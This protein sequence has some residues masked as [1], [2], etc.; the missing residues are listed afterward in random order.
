MKSAVGKFEDEWYVQKHGIATGGS[1]CVELANIAVYF[2][3][4]ERVY[5]DKKLMKNVKH[6]KRY[7]DDGAGFYVGSSDQFKSWLVS[8]NDAIS[9]PGL[10]IDEANIEEVGSFVPF[11]NIKN[12][13]LIKVG[14]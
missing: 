13:V 6:I 1:L 5:N 3:M 8:V 11:L 4:R 10:F 7:I 14:C 12:F 2:I 9:E